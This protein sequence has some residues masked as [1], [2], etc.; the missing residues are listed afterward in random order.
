MSEIEDRGKVWLRGK[1]KPV[2]AVRFGGCIIIPELEQG[3]LAEAWG[4]A[5]GLCVD[6]HDKP[7]G[8]R[9]A[10]WFSKEV[11]GDVP[12]TLFSGFDDTKHAD[13]LAVLPDN[14]AV[15]EKIFQDE[16]YREV[17]TMAPK[18]FWEMASLVET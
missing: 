11:K 15:L 16:A 2:L 12:G 9:I 1:V 4:S 13:I 6:I 7:K 3:D 10:R 17:E 18:I 5:K 14:P 8:I